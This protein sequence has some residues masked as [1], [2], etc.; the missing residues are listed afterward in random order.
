MSLKTTTSTHPSPYSNTN[1]TKV[2]ATPTEV[3]EEGTIRMAL[4]LDTLDQALKDFPG[5][6]H[7]V[8]GAILE[9]LGANPTT[10]ITP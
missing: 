10:R 9:K 2:N 4:L 1:S 3:A 7:A 5:A 8:S 6:A